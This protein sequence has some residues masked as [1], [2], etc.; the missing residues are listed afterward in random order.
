MIKSICPIKEEKN[1]LP[2]ISK[3]L[4]SVKYNTIKTNTK[5]VIE[6]LFEKSNLQDFSN[7][8]FV[9]NLTVDGSITFNMSG[10]KN[11]KDTIQNE[12][13]IESPPEPN[14]VQ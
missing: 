7:K 2:S 9:Y 13:L 4:D 3:T 14:D 8:E 10:Y 12:L 11:L 1:N 6:S 5:D